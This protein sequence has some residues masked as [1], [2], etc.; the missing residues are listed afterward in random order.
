[1]KLGAIIISFHIFLGAVLFIIGNIHTINTLVVL[2]VVNNT[3][4]D[5]CLHTMVCI[6]AQNQ[7]RRAN[8]CT[9]RYFM[10]QLLNCPWLEITNR[11]SK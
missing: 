11:M 9:H 6:P 4:S 8:H 10:N 7:C 5:M 2:P 1:M 3:A